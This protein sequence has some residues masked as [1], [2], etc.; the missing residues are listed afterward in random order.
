MVRRN[1]YIDALKG[2]AILMV[3]LGHSLQRASAFELVE[4]PAALGNYA[5]FSGWVTMPLF[6]AISGYL[7][8]GRVSLPRWKWVGRKAQ[9]LLVPW[10]SWTVVYYFLTKDPLWPNS[11]PFGPYLASQLAAPSL[12]YFV[13][14]FEIYVCVALCMMLGEWAL[15]LFAV[16]LVILWSPGVMPVQYYWW[17][18][19]GWYAARFSAQVVRARWILWTVSVP[20]YII[21]LAFNLPAP[22]LVYQPFVEASYIGFATFATWAIAR[23]WLLEPMAI[24]GRRTLDIYAGQFLFVQFAWFHSYLN[25]LVTTT[26]AI[27][28]PL[29]IGQVLRLNPLTNAVFLGSRSTPARSVDA[30]RKGG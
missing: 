4:L 5:P 2:Y 9:M 30:D 27:L 22:S 20:A 23:G 29:A 1:H 14:L 26:L 17:F 16:G 15:P 11:M 13:T 21:L 8:F 24:M 7:C 3:V 12:W 25:V 6:F 19:S 18:L 28:G 10:L